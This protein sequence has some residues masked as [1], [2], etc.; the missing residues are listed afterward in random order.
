MIAR[1]LRSVKRHGR[2]LLAEYDP[3]N[4]MDALSTWKAEEEAREIAGHLEHLDVHGRVMP[5][6]DRWVI[7]L[8]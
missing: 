7:V 8:D 5:L 6:L 4:G 2:K 1:H 3:S